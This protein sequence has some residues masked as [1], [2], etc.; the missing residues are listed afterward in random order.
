MNSRSQNT[1]CG[2]KGIDTG[3][4]VAHDK[5]IGLRQLSCQGRVSGEGEPLPGTAVLGA[6]VLGSRRDTQSRDCPGA[7]SP[8]PRSAAG[9]CPQPRV[10]LVSSH[11]GWS[12]P[13]SVSFLSL[14]ALCS[15]VV[16]TQP[17]EGSWDAKRKNTSAE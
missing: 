12:F 5:K 16:G 13:T 11:L 6:D 15:W 3:I 14:W 1:A 9:L 2:V 8:P 7:V 10:W 4:L 17:G